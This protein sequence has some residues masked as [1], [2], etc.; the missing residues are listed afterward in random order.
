MCFWV[1]RLRQT[2]RKTSQKIINKRKLM[3]KSNDCFN[4][5]L[6]NEI[7]LQLIWTLNVF[8]SI[9]FLT[10]ER[11]KSKEMIERN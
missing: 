10:L 1:S 7:L 5:E 3:I 11:E 9:S 6:A 4:F 8:T 2:R